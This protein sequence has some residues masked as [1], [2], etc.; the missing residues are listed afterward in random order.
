[1]RAHERAPAFDISIRGDELEYNRIQLENNLQHTELSFRL[2]STS[3]DEQHH[4]KIRH[5]HRNNDSSVEYP[6]HLSEPSFHEFPSIVRSTGDHYA[7]EDSHLH[8]WSYRTGDDEEGINP[9]GGDTVS[10]AAHHASALTLSAGL[11]GGRG[12][13]RDA[14]LSGAEYDPERPLHAMIAGVNSKH[15]MFDLDRS[16]SKVQ[17]FN[18]S[19]LTNIHFNTIKFHRVLRV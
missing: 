7:D 15:S 19:V 2:S 13:R 9:Y 17:V 5:H 4:P 8:P 12:A 16:K 3:D 18:F 1:M 14:S 10:T 11:G 6:R